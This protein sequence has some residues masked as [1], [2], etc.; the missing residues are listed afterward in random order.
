MA[1]VVQGLNRNRM[2]VGLPNIA[3]FPHREGHVLDLA[4]WKLRSEMVDAAL[5]SVATTSERRVH[6]PAF[7]AANEQLLNVLLYETVWTGNN[8]G[9]LVRAWCILPMP[10]ISMLLSG[11]GGAHEVT[12]ELRPTLPLPRG[13][14]KRLRSVRLNREQFGVMLIAATFEV[15]NC[16]LKEPRWRS[17]LFR[18]S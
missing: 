12:P 14:D 1:T 8:A 18:Q 2:I 11:I 9:D 3:N 13:E 16:D 5:A 10:I 4:D 17:S 7:S 6:A 15:A